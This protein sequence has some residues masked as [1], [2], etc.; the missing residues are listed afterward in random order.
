MARRALGY[1][2]WHTAW[3]RGM[4]PGHQD[5]IAKG[6]T[7]MADDLLGQFFERYPSAL[8]STFAG[9]QYRIICPDCGAMIAVAMPDDEHQQLRVH[10]ED[11]GYT[12]ELPAPAVSDAA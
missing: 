4:L 7:I 8:G 2:Q 1:S 5:T 12:D 10:C 6:A 9:G 11:C 3:K